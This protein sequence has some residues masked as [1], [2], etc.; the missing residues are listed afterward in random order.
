MHCIYSIKNTVEEGWS[1]LEI[2]KNDTVMLRRF[3]T[4][5]SGDKVTYK[6][7]FELYKLGDI[8]METMQI[9]AITPVKVGDWSSVADMGEE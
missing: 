3:K 5:L 6:S 8:D 2:A 4:A 1:P 7:D 9:K